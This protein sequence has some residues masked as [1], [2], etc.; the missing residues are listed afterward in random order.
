[1]RPSA[2]LPLEGTA[3]GPTR[4]SCTVKYL[5]NHDRL[6][7]NHLRNPLITVRTVTIYTW[8]PSCRC[9]PPGGSHQRVKL[10]RAP[11]SRWWCKKRHKDL[12]WF[13]QEKAL[14]PAGGRVGIILH[15]SACTG[16]NTS[17][18]GME[19]EYGFSSTYVFC[20]V[21]APELPLL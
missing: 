8:I 21:S 7:S 9:F 17:V 18:E 11:L 1:M 19:M 5:Q 2:I 20:C 12:S 14:R 16:V 15:L 10:V 3:D 13:G 6:L 4:R